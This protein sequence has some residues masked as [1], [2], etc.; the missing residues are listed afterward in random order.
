MTEIAAAYRSRDAEVLAA[1]K[2]A[3]DAIQDY[4]DRTHAV[5]EEAG[6]GGYQAFRATRGWSPGRFAGLGIPSG[7]KPPA[8][9]RMAVLERFAVPDKRVKAGKAIHAALEAVKHPGD[10]LFSLIGMPPDVDGRTPAVRVLENRT[11]LYVGWGVDPVGRESFFKGR[12]EIDAAKWERIP[13]S[14][15]YLAIEQHEAAKAETAAES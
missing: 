4:V 10:P 9:W 12:S 3:G 14:A 1:W 13:L 2:A 6:L 11:A 15:Y 5:L 7:E 8:G